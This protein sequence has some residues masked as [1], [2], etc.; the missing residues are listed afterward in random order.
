LF[1]SGAIT[2]ICI[3]RLGIEEGIVE[4]INYA[5]LSDDSFVGE[6]DSDEE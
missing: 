3:L 6:T 2:S 4:V 5:E 1:V